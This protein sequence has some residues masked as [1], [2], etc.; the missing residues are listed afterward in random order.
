TSLNPVLAL[1]VKDWNASA[2]FY[3][4]LVWFDLDANMSPA[5]AREVP[6]LQNGGVSRDG[7]VVTWRL[8]RNVQWHD[9]KPFTAADVV[10]NWEYAKDP[11]TAATTVGSYQDI[12]V[13]KVDDLT[14]RVLF[15][16]PTPFWAEAFVGVRGM[17][18]PKHLFADYTGAKSRD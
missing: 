18:I 6:S 12:K 5:L 8:K 17:I 4:P 14:V 10:F 1:G 7:T 9:G 2:L 11:A 16:K 3:E 15:E 13:E